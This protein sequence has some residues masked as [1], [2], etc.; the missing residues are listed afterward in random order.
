ML[1]NYIANSRTHHSA[2]TKA[3]DCAENKQNQR[4]KV[5]HYKE[6]F[7]AAERDDSPGAQCG[8]N[9]RPQHR[10]NRYGLSLVRWPATRPARINVHT[11][12]LSRNCHAPCG[13]KQLPGGA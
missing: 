9:H 10:R 3:E 1:I 13:E 2:K 6:A 5:A 4:K 12:P 11:D 8:S 7:N